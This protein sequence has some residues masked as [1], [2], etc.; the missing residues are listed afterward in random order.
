MPEDESVP[1]INDPIGWYDVHADEAVGRYESLA[2]ERINDWVRDFLP[3]QPG[4]ILDVGAGSGRDAAWLASLGH[5]VIAVEPS[6]QMR[7][8]A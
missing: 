6:E 4:L 3:G 5:E 1:A 8:R 7:A 2:P